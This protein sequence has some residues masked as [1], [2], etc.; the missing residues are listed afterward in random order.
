MPLER[1]IFFIVIKYLKNTV[2]NAYS[3]THT[4]THTSHTYWNSF[5]IIVTTYF[6]KRAMQIIGDTALPILTPHL[7]HTSFSKTKYEIIVQKGGG[8]SYVTL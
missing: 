6:K 2:K 8:G 5:F 7:S 3:H 4:I 1:I